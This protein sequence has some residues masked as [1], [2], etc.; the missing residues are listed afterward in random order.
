MGGNS[1]FADYNTT[2]FCEKTI[3]H[4]AFDSFTSQCFNNAFIV[5]GFYIIKK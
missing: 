3:R 4:T 1:T 2:G 5:L